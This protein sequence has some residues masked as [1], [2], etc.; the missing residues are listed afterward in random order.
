MAA[1]IPPSAQPTPLI[2]ALGTSHMIATFVLF[3]AKSAFRALQY[4]ILL[5]IVSELIIPNTVTA[6][7]GMGDG[8]TLEAHHLHTG[9]ALCILLVAAATAFALGVSGAA[10]LR[11]PFQVGVD[12]D[13]NVVFEL[14]ILFDDVFAAKIV[15]IFISKTLG[16]IGIHAFYLE[17]LS[18][19]DVGG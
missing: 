19:L 4:I 16:T 5:Y 10:V 12:L 3:C 18:V 13:L 11:A 7:P 14:L 9:I 17:H 2:P 1:V 6:D 8:T 15:D